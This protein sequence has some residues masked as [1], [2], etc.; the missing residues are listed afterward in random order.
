MSQDKEREDSDELLSCPFCGHD[1]AT[2]TVNEFRD[3]YI[4]CD[5]CEADG[6]WQ[7]I[8]EAAIVAWNTR[9]ALASQQAVKGEPVAIVHSAD[10]TVRLEWAS[11]EAAH[12][13]K[14]GPLYASTPSRE[15]QWQPIETAPKD[16]KVVLLGYH[17]SHGNWRT[18]RGCWLSKDYI[19]EYW[20]YPEGV[21]AG[22]FETPV[23]ADE[24]P[25]CW[26]TDPT[27]WMPL[28]PPPGIH[29]RGE[30]EKA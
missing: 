20:E 5:N 15:P 3:H 28:P 19:D 17:N 23:E 24:P 18:M 7:H 2:M 16:G 12:N 10:A 30:G 25:N 1:E 14:P 22:W 4:T 11:V 13:A 6:P 8:K 27:H 9:A 21:D 29:S 26:P